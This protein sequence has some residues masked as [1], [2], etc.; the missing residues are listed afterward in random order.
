MRI[1]VEFARNAA[2]QISTQAAKRI[3]GLGKSQ[4]A[5]VCNCPIFSASGKE[6]GWSNMLSAALGDFST[7]TQHAYITTRG[8]DSLTAPS[9]G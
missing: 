8:A 1:L 9:R 7:G 4:S 6:R 5:A 2:G 3:I